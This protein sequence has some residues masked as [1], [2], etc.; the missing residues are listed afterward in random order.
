[1][2]S[3]QQNYILLLNENQCKLLKNIVNN[4]LGVAQWAEF[5]AWNRDVAGSNP[6][7]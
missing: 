6:A 1:M 2:M 3:I 7:P 4:E 5:S